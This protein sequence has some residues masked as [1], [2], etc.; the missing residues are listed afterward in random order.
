MSGRIIYADRGG[1]STAGAQRSPGG[2]GGAGMRPKWLKPGVG[3]RLWPGDTYAK[4]GVVREVG[5]HT[6]TFEITRVDSGEPF[7][8]P[9]HRITLPWSSV[10]AVEDRLSCQNPEPII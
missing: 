7:Y 2:A 3:V 4:Y 9:G 8:K 1:G 5:R 10:N 6:V